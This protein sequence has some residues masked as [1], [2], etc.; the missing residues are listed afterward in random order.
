MYQRQRL[1]ATDWELSRSRPQPVQQ[2]GRGLSDGNVEQVGLKTDNSCISLTLLPTGD[3]N[4]LS[5]CEN[6][7][8]NIVHVK[9]TLFTST[10]QR[11]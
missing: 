6:F 1:D 2:R 4:N 11:M 9:N 5:T 3:G 8:R 7:E 10:R